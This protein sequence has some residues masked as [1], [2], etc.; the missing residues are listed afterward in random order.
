MVSYVYDRLAQQPPL[1]LS[2]LSVAD[3]AKKTL[4]SQRLQSITLTS[5]P[6]SSKVS[7]IL[8]SA[9]ETLLKTSF[10]DDTLATSLLFVYLAHTELLNTIPLISRAQRL[11]ALTKELEQY[12]ETKF[13]A[14][15]YRSL[16]AVVDCLP[17]LEAL[18]ALVLDGRIFTLL[19]LDV[20]TS[21]SPLSDILGPSVFEATNALFAPLFSSSASDMTALRA[22]FPSESTT[23]PPVSA[24]P[25][26]TLLPFSN[27]TFNSHFT[28]VH[29]SESIQ[30]TP[31]STI[32]KLERDT[33]F[34]DDTVW[35]G[36][37]P[38][39]LTHQ[40]AAPPVVLDARQRKKKD[41]KDQRYSASQYF[42]LVKPSEH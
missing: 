18:P 38:Q 17:E 30:L 9:A 23:L 2:L 28:A 11:P 4:D 22:H 25:K 42:D 7:D 15:L 20:L 10:K 33:V 19:L 27:P 31:A 13:L 6:A 5:P 39:L 29:V 3:N 8:I 14:T 35:E 24:S 40:G 32:N 21:S 12:L 16:A 36:P 1:S 37:K 34:D 26:C 41:R